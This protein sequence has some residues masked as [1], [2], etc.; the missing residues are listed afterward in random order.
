MASLFKPTYTKTDPKTGKRVTRKTTK[1]YGQFTGPD[2][3]VYR[4]PL[5]RDKAAAQVMLAEKMKAVER[6]EVDLADRF[7]EHRDRPIDRHVEDFRRFL[8]QKGNSPRHCAQTC[9]RLTRLFAGCGFRK[10]RDISEQAVLEWLERQRKHEEGSGA[11]GSGKETPTEKGKDKKKR[12]PMGIK[13]SNYFLIAAKTFCTWMVRNGRLDVNPL[14]HVRPLNAETDVR[15]RR[16]TLT[17][18]Q[19]RKLLAVTRNGGKYGGFTGEDREL[20]YRT[21]AYTGLRAQELD[22]LTATSFDFDST[23]PTVTVEAAYSKRRRRDV[24]P[25]HPELARELREWIAKRGRTE[26]LWPGRW[27]DCAARMLATDLQTA[28]LPVEDASGRVFDFHSLRGQFVTELGRQGVTL[29]EAQKLARH[30]DPRLTANFY[31]H[32]DVAD[33]EAAVRRLPGVSADQES[34]G[35]NDARITELALMLA[36][37]LAP[38]RPDAAGDDRDPADGH[39]AGADPNPFADAKIGRKRPRS[40]GGDGNTP[41]RSRTSDRRIRN[42]SCPRA[43]ARYFPLARLHR[44]R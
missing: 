26:K 36:R 17:A 11:N 12:R 14:V 5:C 44:D 20:L 22:S 15:R 4:V 18:E 32:L 41:E 33:L 10:A 8:E 1:W 34:A 21:A 7:K 9:N 27:R 16:R 43:G 30:S 28:G 3:D 37:I 39:E 13:T 23:P 40:A 38:P 19:F 29:Q 35:E 42:P 25:L 2:G 24:L 6:G 31:T